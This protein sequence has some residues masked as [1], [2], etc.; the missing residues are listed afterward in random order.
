MDKQGARPLSGTPELAANCVALTYDDGPGPRSAELARMLRDEGVPATFFVLGESVERYGDVLETYWECGHTIG[1]HGDHH[2][3]FRSV[4]QATDELHRCRH[5]CAQRVNGPLNGTLWFRPPY[6]ARD[7]PVPGFAGPVG[8]HAQ[9]RDWDITYRKGQTVD[10]CV[11]AI[12]HNLIARRGGIVLLHDFAASAEFVPAGLRESDL[13]LRV[14]E[15]TKALIERV[16]GEGLTFVGLPPATAAAT[17]TAAATAKA[18]QPSVGGEST[19][20]SAAAS[21]SGS[22]RGLLGSSEDLQSL[23]MFRA[24][25]KAAGGAL[26]LVLPMRVGGDGPILFCAHPMVGMSWCYLAMLPHVDARY[27]LYGLQARGLR[28]PE[29]LPTSMREMA[30]DYVD[31][32]RMIQPSGPYHLLGWSLGGNVAF[33]MAE[34]LQRRGEEIGLLVILDSTMV[35]LDAIESNEPWMIYN[36]VLAQFGYV[37]ALTAAD[38]DPEARMLELVRRRPGLGLEDWPDQRLRALQRV[39]KNNVGLA[40]A[41]RPGRVRC[42]LLFFSAARNEPSLAEKLNNW[43]SFVEGPIEVVELDCHHRYMLLPEPVTRLGPALTDRMARTDAAAQ[44]LIV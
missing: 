24:A 22:G 38:A 4:E 35:N 43:G 32:V 17:D 30:R 41:Y 29:P 14:V 21:M 13:D 37:P 34:E 42:P 6:G 1:L 33:A 3:P 44:A 19:T 16:R 40:L 12:M 5:R 20:G 18:T 8:W 36:L 7:I 31:Q 10:G 23:R 25:A 2:Q 26:D 27:P 15:I 39:I 11:D 28:R 9:G